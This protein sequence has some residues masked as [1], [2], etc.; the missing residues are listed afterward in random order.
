METALTKSMLTNS[1]KT[2]L[3]I[4]ILAS[5]FLL[6]TYQL[7]YIVSHYADWYQSNVSYHLSVLNGSALAPYR[8]RVLSELL[9]MPFSLFGLYFQSSI[10]LRVIQNVLI[11][12]LSSKYTKLR[13]P[14]SQTVVPILITVWSLLVA[15]HQSYFFI[16]TYNEIIFYLLAA[17]LAF[18]GRYKMVPAARGGRRT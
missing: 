5:A 18:K 8:Y 10:L 12:W 7:F 6:E 11:L 16:N 13:F 15:S 2:F 17:M 14:N 4:A 9:L 3:F 1:K